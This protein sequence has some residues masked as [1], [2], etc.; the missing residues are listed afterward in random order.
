MLNPL[1]EKFANSLTAFGEA[2]TAA[3]EAIRKGQVTS[4]AVIDTIDSYGIETEAPDSDVCKALHSALKG[5]GEAI[6]A[7]ESAN[8]SE[9]TT[10][11]ED[12]TEQH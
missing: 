1:D 4:K 12:G 7:I 10:D 3:S 9:N 11:A 2:V 8:A 6:D 5:Y